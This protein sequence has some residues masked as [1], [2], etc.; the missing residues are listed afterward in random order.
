MGDAFRYDLIPA[1]SGVLCALSGG[2][3][4]MYLLCRLLEGAHRWGYTVRAAHYDHR[5]RTTA[6]RD[7]DFVRDWC[8]RQEVPLT[9]GSGNVPAQA[10]NRG[11]GLEETARQMRYAFLEK[12]ARQTGCSLVAT[13]HH[14]G[15]NAETVLL[16]LARGCGLNG[17]TGIPERRG[18]LI[19]PMLAVTR[20]EI[21]AYLITHAIPHV[22]DETN[23]DLG[24]VR[25][26]VRHQ[27][28]PLMEQL[29]PRCVEHIAATAARLE[30][31]E[32]ELS[33]QA[34]LLAAQAEAMKGGL[35][36]PV[37]LLSAAPRPIALRAIAQLLQR[38][39]I[40][41]SAYHL[42]HILSL[43]LVPSGQVDLPGGIARREYNALV[44]STL[45]EDPPP[46]PRP[47]TAGRLRWGSWA[48]CCQAACCPAKAYV[49]RWEFYLR[50]D[51]YLIR[52]R[53]IGDTIR[54]GRRPNK[55]VKKLMAEEK[56]PVSRRGNIPVLARD[57]KIAAVGGLGPSADCLAQPGDEALHIILRE[58]G[59][60][61][62]PKQ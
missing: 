6:S 50:P 28:L 43:T 19:R 13:G 55:T 26:R 7:V 56:I 15:D 18:I 42:N 9:I 2:A 4:S 57:G 41:R 54:L 3:D 61:L 34:A 46:A 1:G 35:S 37:K 36:I 23:N 51:G 48:V 33:R 59:P 27:L 49:S 10:A 31:D 44:L 20:P 22:E 53:Q 45:E 16:N 11:L 60:V 29:N 25:N 38:L 30:E 62:S 39:D 32:A 21:E 58:E 40:G 12:I 14:A 52:S 5:I 17:L 8:R 47:L 24:Y